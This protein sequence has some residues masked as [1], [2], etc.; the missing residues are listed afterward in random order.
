MNIFTEL[1]TGLI[2]NVLGF[3]A[4]EVDIALRN[5]KE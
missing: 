4:D 3:V 1:I 2:D 5:L